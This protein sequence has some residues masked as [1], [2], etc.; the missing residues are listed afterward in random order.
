M[1]VSGSKD[2]FAPFVIIMIVME[3]QLV[4]TNLGFECEICRWHWKTN[5]TLTPCPGVVRYEYGSQPEHL[6]NLTYLHKK[7]LKPKP[8]VDPAGVIYLQKKGISLWLYEEKDCQIADRNLP[9]IYQWDA[10]PDLFTVG[11]LRKQNLAPTPDIKPDGVAWVWDNADEWGKWIPLYRISSCIWQPKDS[12]LTK[13][14]LRDKYLLSPKWIKELGKCD[15]KLKNPHGRNAAPIQLYSRQRVE[16]FLAD[17][18]EAYAQW[19]DKRD[20]YIAIFEVNREKILQSRNLTREQT[21]KCLQCASSTTTE[22]GFFCAIH[23]KGLDFIPCR[24]WS[25]R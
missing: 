21:A 17:R 11:E 9:T 22:N 3:H 7:N 6:K 2:G 16:N 5:T 14:A 25:S 12:W 24:D 15:R 19:L 13:S 20:R 18:A 23:P 4:K 10:R 8:G 1:L